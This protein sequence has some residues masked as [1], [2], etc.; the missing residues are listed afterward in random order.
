MAAVPG[1][2]SAQVSWS[3]PAN[4]GGSP[5]TGYIVTPYV[6]STAQTPTTVGGSTLAAT[7]TGLTNNTAYT[8]KVAATTAAGTGAQSS[9]TNA[10]T[11]QKTIFDW[12][13]PGTV[14]SGDGNPVELGV[15]FKSDVAG[16]V[17]GIRFHKA[18]A[19]TGTHIGGLWTSTGT[20]LAS[21]TFTGE[22]AS[23][24]QEV[25]FATPVAI[26]AGTTYVAGYFAPNG[27]YSVGT[28]LGAAVDNPP[29]HTIPNATSPNGLY[30]YVFVSPFP[31]SSFNAS[32]YLV[33]VMFRAG[34]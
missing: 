8:F 5:V 33:D 28:G 24:W 14:D 2:Q 18:A 13:T 21:A 11:P 26:T 34:S 29:L 20:Q 23:G 31:T 19:N 1:S 12:T 16:S 3:A 15:K 22:T 9:A 10:V 27:H 17:T 25:D 7:V 30:S 32:N 4:N 6:G